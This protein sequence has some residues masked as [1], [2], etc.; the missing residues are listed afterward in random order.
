MVYRR[1][2]SQVYCPHNGVLCREEDLTLSA[3]CSACAAARVAA[4][5]MS[6]DH[7]PRE[8]PAA[9]P[10]L[11]GFTSSAST[12]SLEASTKLEETVEGSEE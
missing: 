11:T 10:D 7:G 1:R 6:P 9:G 2:T 4:R 5:D 3:V 12:T 8:T